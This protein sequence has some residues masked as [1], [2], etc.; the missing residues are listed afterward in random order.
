[1]GE[2][3]KRIAVPPLVDLVLLVAA[4]KGGFILRPAERPELAMLG[5]A[6]IVQ[7]F[8][9]PRPERFA[10]RSMVSG[11][12]I[13]GLYWFG[14]GRA[15]D[16]WPLLP[17]LMALPAWRSLAGRTEAFAGWMLRLDRWARSAGR[18][19]LSWLRRAA[20]WA[21]PAMPYVRLAGLVF[22]GV[23]LMWPYLT[24]GI[25]GGGDAHWYAKTVADYVLQ[26]RAGFFPLW[27]AQSD[28]S[29]YG[30]FFPLRLAPYLAHL[31][32]VI[33]L[34]T[35]RQLPPYAIING[36]LVASLVA[37]MLSLYVC[38]GRIAPGRP[39]TMMGLAL[40][41]GLCPG[42]VGMAYAQDLYM[43][44]CTLP[45]LPV[46]FLGAFR[47]FTRNDLGARLLMAGGVA[48]AWLAHPPIGMW[49]GLV[50]GATQVVRLLTQDSWRAGWKHDA[51]AAGWFVLLAGYSLVSVRSLGPLAGGDLGPGGHYLFIQRSFPGNWLPL[52]PVRDLDNLQLGYG[53]A[54]L[55]LMAGLSAR[56]PGQR[57]ARLFL[58][59]AA[60]LVVLL[61]P[62]PFLT[63]YLWRALPQL[64]LNITNVWPM[65]RLFV[66]AALAVAFGVAAWLAAFDSGPRLRRGFNLLLIGALVWGGSEAAKF[67]RE[68]NSSTG[69]WD[70]VERAFRPENRT[71]AHSALG[72][73]VIQPRYFNHGVTDV[74]LEH[75]FLA[76]DTKEIIRNATDAI[77]PGYGP[78]SGGAPRR[79]ARQFTGQL[80]A[81][82]GILNLAPTLTLEPGR[83]YLLALEFLDHDYT[84]VLLIEGRDFSRVYSLPSAGYG[85]AFGVGSENARWL[86]LWQTTGQPTEVRLRWIPAG[87]AARPETYVPFA[88]F[89]FRE[90]DPAALDV[91]LESLLPYR[92]VVRAPAI[93][94]LETP[95]LF[96]P[97]YQ[98]LLDGRPVPVEKSPDGFVMVRLEPGRHVLELSYAAP[99]AT[100]IAY[101]LGLAAWLGFVIVTVRY[102]RRERAQ[103]R[104]S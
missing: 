91:V 6:V 93:S 95:R 9:G 88:N 44:F 29:F 103:W 60:G 5:A 96:I 61:L 52:R 70:K 83:H 104:A 63:E 62:I 13:L 66:L 68:A 73:I 18:H 39:W 45:F 31:A 23:G 19:I 38:L 58:L 30:G 101:W 87:P 85:R 4:L 99:L 7:L 53:L 69:G 46:A 78:G 27:V 51:V 40:C 64:V 94:Q 43:S 24:K 36:A 102:F 21:Q 74:R 42:V 80:D 10:G 100:Q 37:G 8:I 71:M 77:L 33:D 25:V 14:W 84:G 55:G 72:P 49:C 16:A 76:P 41:Y 11:L 65:Q 22:A 34:V 57:M 75:R 98:A 47:S 54:A 67:I 1:M 92:A 28:Y 32:G 12:V 81:N 2:N 3:L 82:P 90:Y 15:A 97:G 20:D 59:C 35:L 50:I 48:G 89:E 26:L 79:L 56:G 17:W 86:A